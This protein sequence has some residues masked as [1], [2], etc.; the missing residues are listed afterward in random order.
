LGIIEFIA[1]KRKINGAPSSLPFSP[2]EKG[3]S[4]LSLGE[5][6]RG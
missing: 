3:F 2:R 1:Y 5:R 6:D 4:S